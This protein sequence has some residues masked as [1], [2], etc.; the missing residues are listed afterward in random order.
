MY[1]LVL[2]IEIKNLD[3]WG[4]L[5]A[6]NLKYS[7]E[8]SKKINLD[9]FIYALGI[10][11]IGQENAKVIAKHFSNIENF[12]DLCKKLNVSNSKH[13]DELQSIDGIGSS[14]TDSLKK[15]FFK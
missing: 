15:F 14:Q 7:I 4:N 11:H 12:F 8:K 3:G 5:S 9:R 10:R 1:I 2:T 6:S 13:I